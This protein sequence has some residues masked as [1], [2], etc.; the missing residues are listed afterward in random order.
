MA[1]ENNP[2]LHPPPLSARAA[3]APVPRTALLLNPFY[4]K[5]PAGSF[6]KHVL[7]PSLALSSLAAVTPPEWSVRIW[8][9]NLLQGTAPV[10]PLPQVVG[11]T[12]HL[13]PSITAGSRPPIALRIQRSLAGNASGQPSA[14]MAMICA[15]HGPMPGICRS[16]ATVW[17]G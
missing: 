4:A 3:G 10:D 6:G 14:H 15:V 17:A 1:R 9:E 7:T 12:V 11:I 5:D 2:M 16:R 13:R 8:D